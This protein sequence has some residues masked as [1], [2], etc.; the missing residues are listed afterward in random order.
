VKPYQR[1]SFVVIDMLI[2]FFEGNASLARQRSNLVARINE[3]G[4]VFRNEHHQVIWVRQEFRPDLKDAFLEMR[5]NE[6]HINIAGTVGCQLLPDLEQSDRDSTIVKKRYSAFF[7]T[8]L[9][10]LL[11]EFGT[12]VLVVGGINT[13]AC[14]RTTVID[15]YQRDFD[16]IVAAE[17]IGSHDLEHHNLTVQYLDG[18]MARFMSNESIVGLISH[19]E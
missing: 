8:N 2:D 9:D 3:L 16:V 15:A 19:E 13:H 11:S 12:E 4:S 1:Y 10:E 18:K 7:G 5:R 14:V 6:I 17:C